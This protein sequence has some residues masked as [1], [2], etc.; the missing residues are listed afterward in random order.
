MSN[1]SDNYRYDQGRS[2]GT[3]SDNNHRQQ[4]AVVQ[5][6]QRATGPRSHGR[7]EQP[8]DL[9]HGQQELIAPTTGSDISRSSR[10]APPTAVGAFWKS[11]RSPTIHPVA[12]SNPDRDELACRYDRHRERGCRQWKSG[13]ARLPSKALS[14]T[15][16]RTRRLARCPH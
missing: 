2:G 5:Q 12:R 15:R 8:E 9:R 13:Y 6:R 16:H 3:R 11:E 1:P 14:D 10:A 7:G 4:V